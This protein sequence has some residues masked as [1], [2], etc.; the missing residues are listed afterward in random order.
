MSDD[1]GALPKNEDGTQMTP[2]LAALRYEALGRVDPELIGLI[3]ILAYDV[4]Y[5]YIYDA[6]YI[7]YMQCIIYCK[8]ISYIIGM[9]KET[10]FLIYYAY[11]KLYFFTVH[12]Y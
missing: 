7:Y 8:Y 12:S 5:I 6:I 2:D 10:Q 4:I 1:A 3:T 11:I 9:Q